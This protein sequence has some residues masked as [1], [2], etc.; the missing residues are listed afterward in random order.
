MVVIGLS[1]KKLTLKGA[2]IIAGII[3]LSLII[4]L[5]LF[6]FVPTPKLVL[7]SGKPYAPIYQGDSNKPQVA[8]M[9]NVYENTQIV[10][11]IVDLLDQNNVKATFFVGGCWADDNK[12]T[13]QKIISS[14][15]SLGNHG[16]FH[17]DHSKLNKSGNRIEIKT[18]H[19]LIYSMCGYK[20]N[21]FAPPSGAFNKST[22]L[23][24][25]KLGYKTVMWTFDTIDWRDSDVNLIVK[26]ATN[27]TFGGLILMH[28]K[29]HTLKA[30]PQIL[31]FYKEQGITAVTVDTLI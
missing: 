24:A 4:I 23:E 2:R 20:M 10:N 27:I 17:K 22:L 8:L 30:L 21:L 14:G 6:C 16:Y 18:T 1:M 5:A 12:Q 29:P 15:H 31:Q 25:E 11:E 26:R 13:I 28:P 19:D 3:S 7:V 9:F